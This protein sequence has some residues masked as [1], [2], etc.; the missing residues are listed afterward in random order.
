MLGVDVVGCDVWAS[1]L[2]IRPALLRTLP[3]PAAHQGPDGKVV[4]NDAW[5]ARLGVSA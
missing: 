3:M 1:C 2:V 4:C 5:L